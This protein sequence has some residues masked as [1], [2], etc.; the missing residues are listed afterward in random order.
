[1]FEG[2]KPKNQCRKARGLMIPFGKDFFI[3]NNQSDLEHMQ[4]LKAKFKMISGHVIQDVYN[5]LQST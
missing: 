1:M 5:V 2:T 3:A 4:D